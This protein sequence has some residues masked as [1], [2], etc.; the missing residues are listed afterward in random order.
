MTSESE[1]GP[2]VPGEGEAG[3]SEPDPLPAPFS[4][5]NGLWLNIYS[6]DSNWMSLTLHGTE[7]NGFYEILT[8]T[9]LSETNWVVDHGFIGNGNWTLA[10][11]IY[12]PGRSNIFF[13]ARN[14]GLDEDGDGLPDWWELEH[15]LDPTLADTGDTGTSDGYK[16]SDQD[17]WSNLE[18]FQNGTAP[19]GF[20]TPPAPRGLTVLLNS[21]GTVANLNWN[22]SGGA[23]TGYTIERYYY[24]TGIDTFSVGVPNS[25]YVDATV[26]V[27]SNPNYYAPSYRIQAHY[28]GGD[29]AWSEIEFAHPTGAA[30]GF[31]LVR[32]PGGRSYLVSSGVSPDVTSVRITRRTSAQSITFDFSW[33]NFVNGIALMP[34]EQIGAQSY[35]VQTL[36]ATGTNNFIY[37]GGSSRQSVQ[38][39]DGR[40]QLKQ[41]LAFVLRAADVTARSISSSTPRKISAFV[42][43]RRITLT[44]VITASL[45]SNMN[46]LRF[47]ANS[48]PSKTTTFIAT[49]L[50]IA[51]ISIHR[52]D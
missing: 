40:E 47:K 14:S 9:N 36:S 15:G 48:G 38:F 25:S 5:T 34:V 39:F 12:L 46:F 51:R 26:P 41:N 30:V 13:W 3:E 17:G 28:A 1:S 31:W 45:I 2:G 21:S 16:D 4:Y 42:G 10:Q 50:L 27:H 24:E 19:N 32:G 37:A 20:N 29:S 7:A 23:V 44:R 8:K 22:P 6:Y 35:W 33:T 52:G 49:S 11:P 18:E 43:A